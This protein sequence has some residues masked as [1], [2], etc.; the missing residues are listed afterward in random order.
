MVIS[1]IELWNYSQG[2]HFGYITSNF[3]YT[4]ESFMKELSGMNITNIQIFD[5]NDLDIH[6]HAHTQ[7]TILI[8]FHDAFLGVVPAHYHVLVRDG[9][10]HDPYLVPDF[11]RGHG[12]DFGTNHHLLFD[13][14]NLQH[15]CHKSVY[16]IWVW[17]G[18]EIVHNQGVASGILSSGR[19]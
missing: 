10:V 3:F 5:K 18:N 7:T 9:G 11:S 8:S 14:G 17:V 12:H 15:L 4:T 13:V 19:K 1:L 16:Q 6:T 2:H